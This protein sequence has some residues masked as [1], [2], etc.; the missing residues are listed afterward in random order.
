MR[1]NFIRRI[2]VDN[3]VNDAN[4]K[5]RTR[6][7]FELNCPVVIRRGFT[8]DSKKNDPQSYVRYRRWCTIFRGRNPYE[9]PHKL[10]I[11]DS[12]VF[13]IEFDQLLSDSSIYVI[14]SRLR[15]RTGISIEF[16]SFE[17]ADKLYFNDDCPYAYWTGEER[18][19]N[20][21][22]A[23]AVDDPTMSEFIKDTVR[24]EDVHGSRRVT[25][26]V[27][28]RT[29]S[30]LYLIEC[31]FSRGAVVKDQL[32]LDEAVWRTFLELL[33]LCYRDDREVITI[34]KEVAFLRARYLVAFLRE[35]GVGRK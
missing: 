29:F 6:I 3:A 7:Y 13:G 25:D 9:F 1:L 33:K 12:P 32:L 28:A 10:A 16:A 14:L 19:K 18:N 34:S 20:V 17:I 24:K 31:L 15:V 5:G 4:G 2:V 11:A 35:R 21:N 30:L 23:T 27:R 8:P 22:A 26:V